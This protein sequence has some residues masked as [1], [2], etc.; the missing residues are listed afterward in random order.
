MKK[1]VLLGFLFL[2]FTLQAQISNLANLASGQMEM[3]APIYEQDKSM[4][5]YFSLFKLDKLNENQE[6]FEY[7]ILD[8]NLNKVANGEFIDD[9]YKGIMSK[10]YTP[11]KIGN[12]LILT[13]RF[14][15]FSGTIA[16][17]STRILNLETNKILDPFYINEGLLVQGSREVENLKKEQRNRQFFNVPIGVNNGFV[18]IEVKKKAAKQNPS[19]I[20]FYNLKQEKLWEYNFGNDVVRE[21]YNLI[22]YDEDLLYFSFIR[23]DNRRSGVTIQQMDTYSGKMN[24]SYL[25]ENSDSKYNYAYNVKRIGDRTI[26]TGKISPYKVMGYDPQNAVGLFK[27]VL[28]EKGNEVFKKH[29]LWEEANEFI[30]MNKKGK[31]EKGYKLFVQSYFVFKDERI[32]VL[33][34]KYKVS[35]NILIGGVLR[36]TD[37]VLLEFDKDFNLTS[38]NT[39]EKDLSKFSAS[40]FLFSQY[41]NDERDAVFFYRDYQKDSETKE[42]N[43]VLGI[44]SLVN[45]NVKHEKVPMSSEDHYI[46]PYIAKEGYILLRELN[47]NSDFD[48]IRLE[49]LNLD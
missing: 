16:F 48:E 45:G 13:K 49:R 17:T 29:F 28:D 14:G 42:R 26:L 24:F 32:V 36:T 4:Y 40:D 7:V 8:K 27:I 15:N 34:E 25:L 47:K 33:S 21:E 12:D 46:F 30:E 2:T 41:L 5:G 3:F 38:A 35:T 23:N 22:A 31:L 19:N 18:V 44:V 10:Y 9:A 1:N 43:W 11:D 37:F 39:I 6:K 20:Y